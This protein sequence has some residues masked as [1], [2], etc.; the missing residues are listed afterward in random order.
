MKKGNKVLIYTTPGQDP[1]E[2]VIHKIDTVTGIIISVIFKDGEKKDRI[3]NVK[4][5]IV[6]AVPIF[7]VIIKLIRS[8]LKNK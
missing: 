2:G 3:M 4:N 5:N 7:N 1:I 6:L 8:L